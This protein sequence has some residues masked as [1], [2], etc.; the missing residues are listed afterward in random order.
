MPDLTIPLLDP[1]EP[2]ECSSC[3]WRGSWS[4]ADLTVRDFCARLDLSGRP[5]AGECPQCHE[6][7][8]FTRAEP[9]LGEKGL[10]YTGRTLLPLFYE[11]HQLLCQLKDEGVLR[12]GTVGGQWQHLSALLDKITMSQHD[13]L[14][15]ELKRILHEQ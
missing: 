8:S 5:P 13:S 14:V 6:L 2:V 4:A 7:V 12:E 1:L 9:G 11:L 3:G 15:V 10:A